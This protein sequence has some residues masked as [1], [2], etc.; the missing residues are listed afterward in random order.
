ME[1]NNAYNAVVDNDLPLICPPVSR[2]WSVARLKEG[3]M[4][5][6]LRGF[7]VQTS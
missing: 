7:S 5:A 4:D 3:K 2:V 1:A 6:I